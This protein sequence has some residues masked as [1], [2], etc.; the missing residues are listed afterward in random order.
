MVKAA[1]DRRMRVIS[2][3]SGAGGLDI[4]FHD[5]GFETAV[6][7]ERGPA[8]C[9]TLRTNMPDTPVIAGDINEMPMKGKY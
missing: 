4:G 7:V 6:M 3:F 1:N 9:R 2:L 8:C 5:A